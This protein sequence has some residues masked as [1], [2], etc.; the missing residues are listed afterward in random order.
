M[1]IGKVDTLPDEGKYEGDM[2][3]TKEPC[4][5]SAGTWIQS[6]ACA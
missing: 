4:I 2:V 6:A 3:S 1:P 5:W